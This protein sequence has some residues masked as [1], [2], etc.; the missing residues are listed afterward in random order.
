MEEHGGFFRVCSKLLL[1][2]RYYTKNKFLFYKN[3]LLTVHT[4]IIVG[5]RPLAYF[6]KIAPPISIYQFMIFKKLKTP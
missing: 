6:Q 2:I 4:K 3:K 5:G 1:E